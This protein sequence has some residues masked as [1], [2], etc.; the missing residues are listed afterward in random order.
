MIA[1]VDLAHSVKLAE[2]ISSGHTEDEAE[3]IIG[4]GVP[5]IKIG[6]V[7]E[8]TGPIETVY[9]FY[10]PSH[11]NE[12]IAIPGDWARV[13]FRNGIFETTD[14][15]K[16][17]IVRGANRFGMYY[18]ADLPKGIQC[19]KCGWPGPAGC[20]SSEAISLHYAEHMG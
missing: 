4:S 7:A 2:L 12:E 10:C 1:T 20:K 15:R 14:P 8:V 19:R 3:L 17:D 9:T 16:A 13:E 18:E 5:G 11:P 6:E